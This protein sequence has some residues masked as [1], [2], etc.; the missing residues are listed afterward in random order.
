MGPFRGTISCAR[1]N[2]SSTVIKNPSDVLLELFLS[3]Y[4]WYAQVL[5]FTL[6]KKKKFIFSFRNEVHSKSLNRSI[7]WNTRIYKW[8]PTICIM[9]DRKS[10]VLN[11]H[12]SSVAG[13]S[14][15]YS[16]SR[17]DIRS[18]IWNWFSTHFL[19]LIWM[20]QYSYCKQLSRSEKRITYV[21]FRSIDRYW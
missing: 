18:A 19:T 1:E 2:P 10:Q 21:L 20:R 3:I 15:L 17:P 8:P 12:Y 13:S 5:L 4:I 11:P 9:Y 7:S 14:V 6:G 16:S